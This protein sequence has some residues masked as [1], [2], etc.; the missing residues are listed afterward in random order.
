MLISRLNVKP[1][2]YH[3][4][5]VNSCNQTFEKNNL[6]EKK[7]NSKINGEK[8]DDDSFASETKIPKKKKIKKTAEKKEKENK[9]KES[10]TKMKKK[11][12]AVNNEKKNEI[13][14]D[15]PSTNQ[16]ENENLEEK[17][18]V[19]EAR[20][21]FNPHDNVFEMLHLPNFSEEERTVQESR[22]NNIP[23]DIIQSPLREY[24]PEF[25]FYDVKNVKIFYNLVFL[26]EKRSFFLNE[27]QIM[28]FFYNFFFF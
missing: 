13:F 18:F 12:F 8:D 9:K 21:N 24:S 26:G 22:E 27:I 15:F 19:E 25:N 2:I 28:I 4:D 16:K 1:Q 17:A 20:E 11:D 3:D 5:T 6:T 10:S 23:F 7:K 14:E